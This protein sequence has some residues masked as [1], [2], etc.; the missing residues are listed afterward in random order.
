MIDY[1]ESVVRNNVRVDAR[2]QSATSV[3]SIPLPY[4]FIILVIS[5]F[6][7]TIAYQNSS[8]AHCQHVINTK[9][10]KLAQLKL[11]ANYLMLEKERIFNANNIVLHANFK[12]LKVAKSG[13]IQVVY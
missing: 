8:I 6:I 3:I 11:K 2:K 4:L 13:D 7:Y 9:K 12:D 5:A 10:S 1:A